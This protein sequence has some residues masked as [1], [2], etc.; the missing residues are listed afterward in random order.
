MKE[1]ATV[2]T[3]AVRIFNN[4]RVYIAG[5]IVGCVAASIAAAAVIE[6]IIPVKEETE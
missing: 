1:I 6:K 2:K 3:R 5:V 4:D